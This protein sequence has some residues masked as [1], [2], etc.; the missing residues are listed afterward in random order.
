MERS[1]GEGEVDKRKESIPFESLTALLPHDSDRSLA[2][3]NE[4]RR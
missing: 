1:K 3:Q 4:G 2:T